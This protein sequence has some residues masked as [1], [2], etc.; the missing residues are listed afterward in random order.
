M[1]LRNEEERY[2]V[3]ARVLH[4]TTVVLFGFQLAG[5]TL[6]RFLEEGPR[7]GVWAVLDAHKTAGLLL[8]GVV[9][10]RLAWRW[11][12]L[13]PAAP[14]TFEA[15][16]R[17]AALWLERGLYA[18]FLAMAASGLVIELAGGYT[19]PF[20]GVFYL[21]GLAPWVHPG[22]VDQGAVVSAARKATGLPWLRDVGVALHVAGTF[23]VVGLVASHVSHVLRHSIGKAAPLSDRM[24]PAH[25]LRRKP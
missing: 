12:N 11:G 15:W 20:F 7:P 14:S 21:D 2:G 8:L 24:D 5:I 22:P 17:R 25:L 9:L 23:A 18:T 10:V 3:V 13:R 19:V 16:D 6:F 4:A 1:R